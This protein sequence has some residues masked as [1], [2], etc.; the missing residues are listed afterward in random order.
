MWRPSA[1]RAALLDWIEWAN[2]EEGGAGAARAAV[3]RLTR[4][5]C[6]AFRCAAGSQAI[7]TWQLNA[8]LEAERRPGVEMLRKRIRTLREECALRWWRKHH[9][10]VSAKA[11]KLRISSL[12]HWLH[13]AWRLWTSMR[14]IAANRHAA[15]PLLARG[16]DAC[17]RRELAR[18]VEDVRVVRVA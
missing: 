4:A 18:Q 16:V 13:V 9:G 17:R 14:A 8:T 15:K 5:A 10:R 3:V 11:A 6:N 1:L 7:R 12:C 2:C